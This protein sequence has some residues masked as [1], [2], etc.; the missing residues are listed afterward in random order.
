MNTNSMQVTPMN[1]ISEEIIN[2]FAFMNN[3]HA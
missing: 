1:P 3:N 2:P